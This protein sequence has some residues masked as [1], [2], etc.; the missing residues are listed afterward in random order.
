MTALFALTGSSAA[1]VYRALRELNLRVP[2]DVSLLSFDNYSWTALVD[3]PVDV[4]E[5]PV[6]AMAQAA[7]QAVLAALAGKQEQVRLQFPARLVI[8]GSCAPV[9]GVPAVQPG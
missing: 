1:G 2:H 6:E 3:P 4:L 8:R 5:Q 9:A 7:A